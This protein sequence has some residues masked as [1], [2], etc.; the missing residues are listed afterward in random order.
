M[1]AVIGFDGSVGGGEAVELAT[2]IAWPAGSSLRVVTVIEPSAVMVG[3]PWAPGG[4]SLSSEIEAQAHAYVEERLAEVG[5][6]LAGPDRTVEGVALRGRPASVIVDDAAGFDANLIIVGSRGH[7]MVAALVL[8]SVSAEVVDHASCPVLVARRPQVARVLYA[9]DGSAAASGAESIIATWPIFAALPVHVVSVADVVQPWHT[10]IAPTM[11]RQVMEAHEKD[12]EEALA[13]HTRIAEECAARLRSAG[14]DAT[15]E[16][17]DGDTA[18]EIIA[19][20][21]E[22]GAD[23]VVV[24]SR[25][26]TGLTRALLGSVAR[27]VAHGSDASVLIV[28]S[29]TKA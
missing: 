22:H 10:G 8:G 18:A 20:A 6:R 3:A 19:A 11:Y 23:L 1:R 21:T 17:R 25:G 28:R 15:A 7:G 12:L 29:G 14:R 13:A 26:R 27:N 16:V 2:S 5:E 4:F 9:T 24:G